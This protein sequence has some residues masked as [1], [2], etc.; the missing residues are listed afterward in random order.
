MLQ[1]LPY[2]FGDASNSVLKG[3]ER[4]FDVFHTVCLFKRFVDLRNAETNEYPLLD[5][6]NL[7]DDHLKMSWLLHRAWIRT[8]HLRSLKMGPTRFGR[9]HMVQ[10]LEL[11]MAMHML[12]VVSRQA[13]TMHFAAALPRKRR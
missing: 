6:S 9:S 5:G 1:N 8:L 2:S 12:E 10:I 13:E 7:S 4:A 11:G 3:V